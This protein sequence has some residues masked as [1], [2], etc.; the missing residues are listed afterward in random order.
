MSKALTFGFKHQKFYPKT[1]MTL[2]VGEVL[3]YNNT[4]Y[5]MRATP[6]DDYLKTR[7]NIKLDSPHTACW[8][9]YIGT[10]EIQDDKLYLIDFRRFIQG[11]LE[12]D[13]EFLFPELNKVFAQWFTGTIRL[14]IG[15]CIYRDYSGYDSVY[16]KDIFLEIKEGILLSERE[17]EN[18]KEDYEL[19]E[20]DDED[21]LPF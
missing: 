21:R 17:V 7:S 16:E 12:S 13:L 5:G 8:R 1:F 11:N 3:V 9:G 6:L 10:W 15:E 18:R 4:Q 19:P 2:Q 20:D 14:P